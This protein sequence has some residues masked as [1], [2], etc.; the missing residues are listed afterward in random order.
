MA[1]SKPKTCAWRT[2]CA[3]TLSRFKTKVVDDLVRS[4]VAW[5]VKYARSQT[6][7]VIQSYCM[8]ADLALACFQVSVRASPT[9]HPV[10][11]P[12]SLITLDPARER[13][14]RDNGRNDSLSVSFLK[15][16]FMYCT[17]CATCRS[18]KTGSRLLRAESKW[19]VPA[20][21]PV[22]LLGLK[23]GKCH[24]KG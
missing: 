9:R 10:D 19:E 24:P 7:V 14:E 3:L 1:E 13:S 12:G 4:K 16:R 21:A 15:H 6:R 22:C 23:T 17:S 18:R 11:L 5:K 8:E 20:P 2:F